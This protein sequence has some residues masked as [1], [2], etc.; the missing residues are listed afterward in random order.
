[1]INSFSFAAGIGAASFF[2]RDSCAK[3]YSV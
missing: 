3:R 1:L 2:V